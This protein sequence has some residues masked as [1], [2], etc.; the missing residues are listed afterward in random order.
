MDMNTVYSILEERGYSF[1]KLEKKQAAKF[2][3]YDKAFNAA[4]DLSNRDF[5]VAQHNKTVYFSNKLPEK[6]YTEAEEKDGS[7]TYDGVV[8]SFSMYINWNLCLTTERKI[9]KKRS[10]FKGDADRL[11][12]IFIENYS[13]FLNVVS[14]EKKRNGLLIKNF[15][16]FRICFLVCFFQI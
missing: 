12:T 2:S 16:G 8:M 11:Y 5:S 13:D 1:K 7:I 15:R 4:F 10:F 6:P 14:L 9:D 3:S